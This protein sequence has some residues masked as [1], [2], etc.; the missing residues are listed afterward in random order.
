MK[1]KNLISCLAV[2]LGADLARANY[3]LETFNGGN[4]AI[5][6]GNPVGIKSVGTVSDIPAGSTVSG[7]TVGLSVSGGYNGSLY[8]YLVAPN[9]QLVTLMNQP[10]VTGSNPFGYGGSGFNV[11]FA[12]TAAGSIQNAAEIA[13]AVLT[14]NYQSAGSLANVNG[15]VADGAWTL[16]VSSEANGGGQARLNNWSLGITTS[17]AKTSVGEQTST[18]A[19]LGLGVLSIV[20]AQNLRWRRSQA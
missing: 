13:G 6:T 12:D 14:G 11:T 15:S 10:G 1:L 4:T 19:L 18:M 8:A 9:G 17:S 2:V 7:L 20:A 16:F 3:S 5:P